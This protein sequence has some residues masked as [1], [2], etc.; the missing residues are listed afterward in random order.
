MPVEEPPESPREL[1]VLLGVSFDSRGVEERG[2]DFFLLLR[3]VV[4]FALESPF[5]DLADEGF[6]LV[7]AAFF[8]VDFLFVRLLI[9]SYNS[10]QKRLNQRRISRNRRTWDKTRLKL[11][12]VSHTGTG[13][14]IPD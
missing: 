5:V 9:G 13:R 8:R 11:R 6:R 12:S 1:P 7:V 3:R 2:F 4:P 14:Y 10:S